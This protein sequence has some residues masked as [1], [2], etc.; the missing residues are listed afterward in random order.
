[1]REI[2]IDPLTRI[3]GHM[4]VRAIV[5]EETRKPIPETVRCFSTMF[6]G[7]EIFVRGREVK[8]TIHITSRICGVCGASHAM[9]STYAADMALGVTPEPLGVALRNMA[10]GMA[11]N[12]YDHSLILNMLGGP[13]YSK[14]IVK[15]LTPSIYG[16]AT[17]TLAPNRSIHGY[18]KI[19]D[20]MDALDPLKGKIWRQTIKYQRLAREA[21]VLIWGRHSHPSTLIPG[22]IMTDL[23]NFE[24]L[25]L[26]YAYRL[27]SLTAWAKY[28]IT[29]WEDMTWFFKERANYSEQGR[30][31]L[32]YDC[33]NYPIMYSSGI[34]DDPDEYAS[35][36][37]TPQEIYQ[38][39]DQN[40]EKRA[41]K[42]G[43]ATQGNSVVLVNTKI[44]DYNVGVMEKIDHAF[45]Q[46]WNNKYTETDYLGNQLLWGLED[47]KWHPWN[48]LTIPKPEE[49]DWARKYT[50][51]STVRY[52]NRNGTKTPVELG[53]ISRLIIASLHSYKLTS[54]ASEVSFGN[55]KIKLTLPPSRGESDLPSTVEEELEL[56]YN[57]PS[58]STT[59]ERV[60]ARAFNLA[61]DVAVMWKYIDW[62]LE[63]TKQGNR[64]VTSKWRLGEYPKEVTFGWGTLE[65]PRGTV[66]HWIVQHKGKIINYQ[67]H[68]PTTANLSSYD[69]TGTSPFDSSVRT[70]I[71]TEETPPEQWQGL[72]FVRAI[73]SFDPCLS[74]SV[75]LQFT[76]KHTMRLVKKLILPTCGI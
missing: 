17:Q 11:D 48:K 14:S 16:E 22:G 35:L 54:S 70:S 20:I 4:G 68:A 6:R 47:P 2:K 32:D 61:I 67:L 46:D 9:S 43:F 71:V 24:S 39:L 18:E 28:L 12:I 34:F 10:Y 27:V 21:A 31:C 15:T 49:R 69:A 38:N 58:H 59:L 5:D 74:C 37:E 40:A 26:E 75:H 36:G 52:I 56:E 23:T 3:E 60:W 8:D 55:G 44:T 65:A 73:R 41:L 50:W 19:S 62:I 13:D 51:T 33:T 1:M 45:Y 72:D 42:P 63:Y 66:N 25:I 7:F 53:P 64:I 57:A 29:I 30:T 76:N